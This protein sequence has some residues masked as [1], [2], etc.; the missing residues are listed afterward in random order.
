[1]AAREIQIPG[2]RSIAKIRTYWAVPL[3]GIVTLGIY[4]VFWY[5]F[6]NR[7][8]RDFGRARGEDLGDSPGKSVLAVTLGALVIV[9]AIISI[10]HTGQRIQKA[11]RLAGVEP[12]LNGWLAVVMGLVIAPVMYAYFQ[13]ELNKVWE[14]VGEE[15]AV[16]PGQLGQPSGLGPGATTPSRVASDAAGPGQP[17]TA[18]TVPPGGEPV[19]TRDP[20]PPE[21]TPLPGTPPPENR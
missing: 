13:Y 7:E 8:L 2:T 4:L 16:E 15:P 9:P 21:E 6:I 18:A 1:M 3:L 10:V 5:Y 17:G 14:R 19:E 12:Q 11:Q 20:T